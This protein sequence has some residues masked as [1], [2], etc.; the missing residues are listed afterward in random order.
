MDDSL[1][2]SFDKDVLVMANM[3]AK[4]FTDTTR[5]TMAAKL[6][7]DG[8]L[9]AGQAARMCGLGKVAFLDELPKHGYPMSNIGLEDLEDDLTFARRNRRMDKESVVINTGPLILL[10]KI[11]ADAATLWNQ[12]HRRDNRRSTRLD[13]L[14]IQ[15]IDQ[16]IN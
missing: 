16:W 4:E 9:T 2:V 6:W 12:P 10:G 5:F 13:Y 8:K 3:T 1:T 14:A 15:S 7:M 11:G